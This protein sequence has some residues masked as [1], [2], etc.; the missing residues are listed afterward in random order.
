MKPPNYITP[1][2]LERITRELEFLQKV[3]RPR[4]TREVA[5]AAALGDRSENAE[6]LYGKKRLRKIDGRLRFLIGRLDKIRIVDPAGQT[7]RKVLFG[8]T[9]VVA[10][11]D[12]S[13]RTWTIYG[14]DEVDV[15]GGVLS[16]RSPLATA[17]LG[18]EEGEE[19]SFR[20]PAGLRT[21]EIVEVRYEPQEPLPDG[22]E[23][24]RWK[25]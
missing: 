8:A 23:Q 11:E 3:E 1:M 13:E 22:V 5:F 4:I 10:D 14:E 7:G 25:S 18:H 19:V 21:L 12:G 9:V 17:L 6:Y 20:A 24:E 16:W 15:E 2:G